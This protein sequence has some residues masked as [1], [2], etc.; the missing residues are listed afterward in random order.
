MV[1]H[2][3]CREIPRPTPVSRQN[4]WLKIRTKRF[5]RGSPLTTTEVSF[6][7]RSSK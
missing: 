1:A 2:D 6:A 7:R 5:E 4:S 3:P